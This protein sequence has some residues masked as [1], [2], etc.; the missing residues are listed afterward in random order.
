MVNGIMQDVFTVNGDG[1]E[2]LVPK[3][4]KRANAVGLFN[5]AKDAIKGG[6]AL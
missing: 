6:R 2:S 4:F 5:L 3:L 1:A